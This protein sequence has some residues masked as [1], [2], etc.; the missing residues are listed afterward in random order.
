VNILDSQREM[1]STFL[2][3]FAGQLVSGLS[4]IGFAFTGRHVAL[5]EEKLENK[6]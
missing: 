3:G 1:R 5:K 6:K 4:L 2:G